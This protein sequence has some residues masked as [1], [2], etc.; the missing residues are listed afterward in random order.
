MNWNDSEL[1]SVGMITAGLG[2]NRGGRLFYELLQESFPTDLWQRGSTKKLAFI[3]TRKE[4]IN[5]YLNELDM[6]FKE[7][8]DYLKTEQYLN[9]SNYVI[10][11]K[12]IANKFSRDNNQNIR[13]LDSCLTPSIYD[14]FLLQKSILMITSLGVDQDPK[15]V[16]KL[17]KL[18]T[19]SEDYEEKTRPYGLILEMLKESFFYIGKFNENISENS[20]K[21]IKDLSFNLLKKSIADKEGLSE[22]AKNLEFIH[23]LDYIKKT[24]EDISTVHKDIINIIKEI[25]NYSSLAEK[26]AKN[27]DDLQ[28]EPDKV[29]YSVRQKVYTENIEKQLDIRGLVYDKYYRF[30][31]GSSLVIK[32]DKTTIIPENREDSIMLA[33]D[34]FKDHV[35]NYLSKNPTLSKFFVERIDNES[36]DIEQIKIA[37]NQL[38]DNRSILKSIGFDIFTFT[39]EYESTS[40]DVLNLYYFEKLTD[41]MAN[42]IIEHKVKQFADSIISSKYRHLY[43]EE[44]Y[45]IFREMYN[46]GI[47]Q[48][49]LQQI[50]GKK[51]AAFHSSESFNI[52]LKDTYNKMTGFC[53]EAILRKAEESDAEIISHKDNKIIIKI[54]NYDQ[55]NL[56]GSSNWCI[57][58]DKS[59]FN[60]YTK[61][62]NKQYFVFDF[63]LESKDEMSMVG[64]TLTRDG[65]FYTAHSKFDD[66]LSSNDDSIKHI[67]KAMAFE[68]VQLKKE[69]KKSMNI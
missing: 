58:R 24:K 43:N 20:E 26:Y 48:E 37:I 42:S 38:K 45:A 44:S 6:T 31:D 19:L 23:Y 52:F 28:R 9:D 39:K 18:N 8:K 15:I 69:S 17:E 13:F 11:N 10:L 14:K 41:T 29:L 33:Y 30:E 22:L 25:K 50:I 62:D 3:E 4:K 12:I 59:Y 27:L 55:S 57:S 36:V 16:E 34:F 2:A 54:D 46:E 7:I 35:K 49:E 60:S 67:M 1:N 61:D 51:I 40:D 53:S 56:L 66:Q 5:S 65:G 63:N 68:T 32:K 47:K 21:N 64:I